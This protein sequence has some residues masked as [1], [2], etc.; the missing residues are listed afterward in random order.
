MVAVAILKGANARAKEAASNQFANVH[1][2]H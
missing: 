2:D 1:E